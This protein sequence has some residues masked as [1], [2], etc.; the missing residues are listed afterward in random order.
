MDIR[1]ILFFLGIV[2]PIGFGTHVH[3]LNRKG[4]TNQL[5]LAFSYLIAFFFFC[6]FMLSFINDIQIALFWVKAL[7]LSLF[8]PPLFLCFIISFL[9]LF[10]DNNRRRYLIYVFLFSLPIIF[11]S[12]LLLSN[13]K[14]LILIK[15]DMGYLISTPHLIYFIIKIWV[16]L[17][18]IASMCLYSYKYVKTSEIIR[19]K[20]ATVLIINIIIILFLLTMPLVN[21]FLNI[22]P[23]PNEIYFFTGGLLF[24]LITATY[25]VRHLRLFHLNPATASEHI[26]AT[27]KDGLFICDREHI[28]HFI[29]KFA[30]TLTGFSSSELKGNSF[31]E[32]LFDERYNPADLNDIIK[33]KLDNELDLI[34]K[35]KDR[36]SLPC[37]CIF[38]F[39]QVNGAISPGYIC[40]VRNISTRK[41]AEAALKA[42][43]EKSEAANKAKSEFLANMSHEIR[44]PLNTIL[45]MSDMLKQVSHKPEQ[46]EYIDA[47]Y[48][49]G[50][51]LLRLL[52][53]VLDMAQIESGKIK[54]NYSD[55]NLY[56]ISRAVYTI[57]KQNAQ[58]GSKNI[59]LL[60]EYD[61]TMP[62]WFRGDVTR[63]QEILL[64]LISNAVKFT[65]KGYVTLHISGSK[66]SGRKKYFNVHITIEDTGIGIPAS[67]QKD[68]FKAFYQA[69]GSVTRKYGG[70]GLGLAIISKL[71]SMMNGKIKVASEEGKG[72]KF[73]LDI[74]LTVI[75]QPK[76][77]QV[78][79]ES[80]PVIKSESPK[81][82]VSKTID[83]D[84]RYILIAEDDD[85][86]RRMLIRMVSILGYSVDSV[87]NGKE[88]LSILREKSY[89]LILMDNHMPDMDGITATTLIRTQMHLTVPII[90]LTGDVFKDTKEKCLK[91]GMNHFLSKPFRMDELKALLSQ[92]TQSS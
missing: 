75:P 48:Y 36:G 42:A 1:V 7:H 81:K 89:S 12:F 46:K 33:N 79:I 32:F 18:I 25:A 57:E 63:I 77:K 74:P 22:L 31:E 5:F 34:L 66:K 28:I 19:Q 69:D 54:I 55:F 30:S 20:K 78:E 76:E 35:T 29:N 51:I 9:A 45:G 59:G 38:S 72:T 3:L 16:I 62:Q 70:S 71:I 87:A 21:Y 86:N 27:I 61:S 14:D 91:A 68:I 37:S 8:L 50:N 40:I 85:L 23:Q 47:I 92:F 13:F 84:K 17:H 65:E 24:T 26:I 52:N 67:K 4:T 90:G 80:P 60:F 10:Q 82:T 39:F 53:N 73:T 88:V 49:S 58:S 2:V 43:K 83:P 64:N 15:Q 56:E 11:W 44:T 41:V 6:H